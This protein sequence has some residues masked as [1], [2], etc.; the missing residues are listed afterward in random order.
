MS[1]FTKKVLEEEKILNKE[2]EDKLL[3]KFDQFKLQVNDLLIKEDKYE[4]EQENLEKEKINKE[5]E[6]MN[7]LLRK[8][9]K[10][11]KE[12]AEEMSELG[13]RDLYKAKEK[14]IK[15]KMKL[16]MRDIQKKIDIKRKN[17]ANKLKRMKKLHILNQKLAAKK[18]LNIKKNMGKKLENMNKK[19]S[20]NKCFSRTTQ[21][22]KDYCECN[23]K[24]VL[25]N[26]ECRNKSQFCYMCC[27]NEIGKFN[28]ENLDCCYNKCDKIPLEGKCDSFINDF[29]ISKLNPH[30]LL[31][32][33]HLHHIHK[34][35]HGHGSKTAPRH[36]HILHRHSSHLPVKAHI[37]L[38]P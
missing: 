22:I 21:Q 5:K 13:R 27:D 1:S 33:A 34:L 2:R 10:R 24:D 26:K 7:K 16:M 6:D 15:R 11:A 12:L 37:D 4:Q 3:K 36:A 30:V 29:K 38:F 19:G 9:E 18:L 35:I 23:Y 17:L 14:A 32:H 25:L 31:H 28:K 20:P 8:E